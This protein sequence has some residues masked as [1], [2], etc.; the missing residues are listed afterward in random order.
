MKS[1]QHMTSSAAKTTT[2]AAGGA[3]SSAAMTT[4]N[5]TGAMSCPAGK[6]YVNG[7]TKK[8]GTKVAGYCRSKPSTS[9]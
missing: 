1:A 7:Y 9:K 2:S 3:M 8:D 5:A 4:K 6:T